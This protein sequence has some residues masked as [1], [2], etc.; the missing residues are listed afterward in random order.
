MNIVSAIDCITVCISYTLT[1]TAY[2]VFL[3]AFAKLRKKKN[4]YLLRHVCPSARLVQLD[5]H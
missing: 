1:Q 4:Y 2:S 5:S 3:Q